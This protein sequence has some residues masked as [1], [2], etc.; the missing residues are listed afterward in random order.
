MTTISIEHKRLNNAGL[1]YVTRQSVPFVS[2]SSLYQSIDYARFTEGSAIPA[3]L[4]QVKDISAAAL[5][6]GAFALNSSVVP[7]SA[8]TRRRQVEALADQ[9]QGFIA[10]PYLED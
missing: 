3:L 9:I 5:S 10:S 6:F 4:K 1:G 8:A 2:G 7:S